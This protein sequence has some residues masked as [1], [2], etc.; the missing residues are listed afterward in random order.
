MPEPWFVLKA[1]DSQLSG[2]G[3]EPQCR[4]L[5]GVSKASYCFAKRNKGSQIGQTKKYIFFYHCL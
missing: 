1:E 2:C 4:K 5:D 3:V